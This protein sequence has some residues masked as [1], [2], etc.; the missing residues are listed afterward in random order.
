MPECGGI[1]PMDIAVLK[2]VSLGGFWLWISSSVLCS[3][4]VGC[5]HLCLT[6]MTGREQAVCLASSA[7]VSIYFEYLFIYFDSY[8]YFFFVLLFLDCFCSAVVHIV[9]FCK[10][11]L[12]LFKGTLLWVN[13]T[14]FKGIVHSICILFFSCHGKHDFTRQKYAHTRTLATFKVL[15]YWCSANK[16]CQNSQLRRYFV[17]TIPFKGNVAP[18]R[19]F[20]CQGEPLEPCVVVVSHPLAVFSATG[21]NVTRKSRPCNRTWPPA[22]LKKE[23]IA[24]CTVQRCF[25]VCVFTSL[26]NQVE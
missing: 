14:V 18:S 26:E 19:R 4:A 17:W 5:L 22:P 24:A 2:I 21:S 1:N 20:Y 3:S 13:V 11:Y 15:Q 12:L 25:Y 8:F 7:Q 10:Y 9:L 16:R 23:E 6:H